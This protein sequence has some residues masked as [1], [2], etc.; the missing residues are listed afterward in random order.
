MRLH[1]V[2][3]TVKTCK[4]GGLVLTSD[5][6]LAG[7]ADRKAIYDLEH[8]KLF[9]LICCKA[10]VQCHWKCLFAAQYSTH[11]WLIFQRQLDV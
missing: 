5:Q 1:Y 4:V 6:L 11:R 2:K 8:H 9:M 10:Y 3:V 7:E